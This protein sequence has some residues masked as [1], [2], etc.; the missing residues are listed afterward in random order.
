MGEEKFEVSLLDTINIFFEMYVRVLKDNQFP[1]FSIH[2]EQDDVRKRLKNYIPMLEKYMLNNDIKIDENGDTVPTIFVKDYKIFFDLLKQYCNKYIQLRKLD[3]F[4]KEDILDALRNIWLR[5]VSEDFNNVEAFLQKQVQMAEYKE[6]KRFRT[7]QEVEGIPFLEYQ[8]L[9][10]KSQPA[11]SYDENSLEFIFRLYD[12][13]QHSIE[14]PRIRYGIIEINGKKFCN[15]GSIQDK[16]RK[17]D[18]KLEK[19][20]YKINSNID[21][22]C[23]NVEPKNV[24]SLILFISLM[25]SMGI[26]Y[27]QFSGLSIL[28]YDYHEL[29]SDVYMEKFKK[30][31]PE[32]QQPRDIEY[33]EKCLKERDRYYQQ[34]DRILEQKT[35]G[36]Y[37]L[38]NR[39]LKH[40]TNGEIIA[41]PFDADSHLTITIPD[42][43]KDCINGTATEQLYSTVAKMF[44]PINYSIEDIY[45][46]EKCT[47]DIDK[48]KE[49]AIHGKGIACYILGLVNEFGIDGVKENESSANRY[50]NIGLDLG[51]PRCEV[52]FYDINKMTT[53]DIGTRIKE[54]KQQAPNG[55]FLEQKF[56][57]IA[58]LLF[59]SK[60]DIIKLDEV[61][62]KEEDE[63]V[64]KYLLAVTE[65]RKQQLR[66]LKKLLG[67]SN[68]FKE[69]R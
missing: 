66:E 47:F 25:E 51:D 17:R 8:Y 5:A 21:S 54:M 16:Q 63:V 22:D 40:F 12:D 53:N 4:S 46:E 29:L 9:T 30:L 39:V 56:S 3:R 1:K 44:E 26:K 28:D 58:L 24:I 11:Q 23:L 57:R 19:N 14:L 15:I 36:L 64:K 38:V 35:T 10:I 32:D 41:F 13:A 27:F 33:Y 60:S 55:S 7:E 49:L 67:G 62:E 48:L 45:D 2:F 59:L 68:R 65:K 20:R 31:F 61:V 18:K 43:S 6:D 50:Y 69:E 37:N 34:Q 52:H 42:I